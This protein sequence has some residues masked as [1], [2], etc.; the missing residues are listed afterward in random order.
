MQPLGHNR[1]GPKIG[2]LCPFRGGEAGSPSDTK[3]PGLRPTSIPS[4]IL[5]H[6]AVCDNK[7]GPKIWGGLCPLF[8]GGELVLHLAQCGLGRGL[9]PYQAAS[10]SIQPFGHNRHGPKIGWSGCAFFLGVA[11]PTSNTISR[12]P[13]PTSVPS[14]IL[15][16]AAVWPQ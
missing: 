3:S 2:G 6:P 1:K 11:G 13:R 16:H 12:R 14:V 15:I 8:E 7:N 9:L 10:S 4:G 5:M